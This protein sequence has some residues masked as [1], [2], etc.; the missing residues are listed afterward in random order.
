MQNSAQHQNITKFV[1]RTEGGETCDLH[2]LKKRAFLEKNISS[3]TEM[4]TFV[5]TDQY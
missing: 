2:N 1:G 4:P 5:Q 3:P